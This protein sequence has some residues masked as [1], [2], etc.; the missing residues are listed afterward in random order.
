MNSELLESLDRRESSARTYSRS[1]Q[2]VLN[3][4]SLAQVQDDQGRR[5]IDCLACAGALPLGHNHPYVQQRVIEFLQSGQLQQALDLATPAKLRFMDKLFAALPE[6][7]SR[8]AKVQFCGPT[9]AD[10]VEAALKLFKTATGRRSVLVFQGA[11]HGMTHATLGMMGNLAPK[12]AISGMPAEVQFLPFPYTYRSPFGAQVDAQET[13][14]LS[15]AYLENLLSD[16]ESGVNKPAM[17]LVEPIQGE[18]GCIPASAEWLRQVREITARHDVPLVVD[19]VQS[20]IGRSGD[21]F[22]FEHAGIV[23]DAVL[24][25]KAIGGGYPLSV[26][27]YRDEYDRWQPGAHAGTFRGNQIALVSGA[28]TLDFLREENLLAHVRR[29]GERLRQGLLALQ[30]RFPCIGDVRGRGLM[31][32]VE[33]IDPDGAVDALGHPPAAGD[34]AR[35]VKRACLDEGLIIESGGRHGAVLRFLPPLTISE[36]EIDAILERLARALAAQQ[37]AARAA[38]QRSVGG[39]PA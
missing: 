21:M 23:P 26:L 1:I 31:I 3:W 4:G 33:L 5:Y 2:R 29:T 28:A 38:A 6:T 16:P 35:A 19:E 12:Q 37:P 30:R 32:G 25:S 8:Q 27:V 14:R 22:A 17:L 15:L 20:G 10:A 13:E 9:G 18:G 11:Y 7:L 34:L 39:M 36:H 24:L